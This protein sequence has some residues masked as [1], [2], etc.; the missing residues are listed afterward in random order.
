MRQ[1]AYILLD[2]M[3]RNE[4]CSDVPRVIK[5]YLQDSDEVDILNFVLSHSE[6]ILQVFYDENFSNVEIGML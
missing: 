4:Q 5:K 3:L 6:D 2:T 1:D